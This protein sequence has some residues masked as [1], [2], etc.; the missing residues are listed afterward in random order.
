MQLIFQFRMR[1]P[2]LIKEYE[3]QTVIIRNFIYKISAVIS[4]NQGPNQIL[5]PDRKLLVSHLV[6]TSKNTKTTA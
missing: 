2:D 5:H 1:N 6:K 4:E 3:P